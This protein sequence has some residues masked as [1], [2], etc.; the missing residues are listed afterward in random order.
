MSDNP[1]L[2]WVVPRNPL[3]A[4]PILGPRNP[5]VDNPVGTESLNALS[6]TN[7]DAGIDPV[8]QTIG[9][10][11]GSRYPVLA[12]QLGRIQGISGA[13]P[14]IM[15]GGTSQPV[16]RSVAAGV[17]GAEH[18]ISTRIPTAVGAENAHQSPHFL[19]GLD[20]ILASPG[21]YK[22]TADLI[23]Q[24]PGVRIPPAASDDAAVGAFVDHARDNILAM[25]DSIPRETAARTGGWYDGANTMAHEWGHEF[26]LPPQATAG[27]MAALSP[28]MDW[29]KNVEQARRVIQ[30][31]QQQARTALTPE[32]RAYGTNYAQQLLEDGKPKGAADIIESLRQFDGVPLKDITGDYNRALDQDV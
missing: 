23:R 28:N 18:L 22:K 17:P 5:Y 7:P 32:M 29:F 30:T 12:S 27:I 26:D 31:H 21:A 4:G 2:R 10:R 9:D 14:D 16:L 25:H 11:A 8:A 19:V 20:S 6:L 13:I 15:Y 1:L 24:Y 3:T